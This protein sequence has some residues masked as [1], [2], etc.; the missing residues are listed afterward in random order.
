[1]TAT[2]HFLALTALKTVA[3]DRLQRAA[4]GLADGSLPVTVTHQSESEIRA[5]VKDYGVSI[6]SGAITC[7]CKDSMFRGQSCKHIGALALYTLRSQPSP[8]P[9]SYHVGDCVHHNGHTG[10]VIAVSGE[11][12]SILWTNG[13]IY[14]V[15]RADLES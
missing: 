4:C 15:T 10:T 2:H 1:M 13:R 3:P 7:S 8:Q 12:V 6:R 9:R 5:F 11:Y 14:P